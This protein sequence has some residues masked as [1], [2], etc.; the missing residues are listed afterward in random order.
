MTNDQINKAIA[1]ELGW[2]PHPKSDNHWVLPDG[3]F[4]VLKFHVCHN[5]VAEMRKAIKG[6][7]EWELFLRYI[8]DQGIGLSLDATPLQQ[9][10]A[11]LKMRGKWRE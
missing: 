3:S 11:F 10:K 5:A 1:L 2:K 6:R 8:W 4:T 9:C 7:V